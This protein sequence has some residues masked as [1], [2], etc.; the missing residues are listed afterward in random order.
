[1]RADTTQNIVYISLSKRVIVEQV[2]ESVKST[3]DRRCSLRIS[4]L[5]LREP[6]G[7]KKFRGASVFKRFISVVVITLDFDYRITFQQPRFEPGMDLSFLRLRTLWF[8]HGTNFALARYRRLYKCDRRY[9]RD[10]CTR[11]VTLMLS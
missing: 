3:S 1:M 6:L 11:S 7:I 10:N 4:G 9:I 2:V 8:L 5:P